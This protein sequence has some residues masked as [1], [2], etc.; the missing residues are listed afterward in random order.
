MTAVEWLFE[1]IWDCPKD[2]LTW[3]TILKKAKE[4]EKQQIIDAY[5]GGLNGPINDYSDAV[6][7]IRYGK[8]AEQY[9]NETYGNNGNFAKGSEKQYLSQTNTF[10]T[11]LSKVAKNTSFDTSSQTEISD[12]E[13]NKVM[14]PM[15]GMH[16]F[17]KAG[18][19]EG[20]CWYRE[21]L[22]KKQ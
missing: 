2:K 12:E 10:K 18:F 6:T 15:T 1:T 14:Q 13:I 20:A 16:E 8:G 5:W 21:Q 7:G 4:M 3:Y 11:E 22:K 19:V 17:Y 9:Y